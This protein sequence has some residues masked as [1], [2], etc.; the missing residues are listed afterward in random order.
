[1]KKKF[2]D[3]SH[4]VP[5]LKKSPSLLATLENFCGIT[6]AR[7]LFNESRHDE[8]PF[9]GVARRLGM[10]IT[11]KGQS[12]PKEGPVVVVAN[13][14]F[15]G[16]DALAICAKSIEARRE[17]KILANAE[18]MNLEGTQEWFL[19]VSLLQEGSA[20]KENT[21]SLRAMLK[22]VRSGG[23][24][25]VFPGG[26]VAVWRDGAMRDPLWN[27]HVVTLM[28]R[29]KA[30][31]VPVWFYG[32]NPPWMRV[33]SQLS[34]MAKRALIPRGLWEMRNREIIAEVGES[35]PSSELAGKGAEGGHW[36]RTKIE[37]LA[38]RGN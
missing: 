32:A 36:L 26:Q 31:I 3:L 22:H 18:L 21:A 33:I 38:D 25:V 8:N 14:A 16:P 30:T 17:V 12:I 10:T 35:F 15:G 11:F 37:R 27:D 28:Q 19:P 20:A 29:M 5:A 4:Y 23:C 13:H 34:I 1:M 9:M 2:A 24:L 7:R 6:Q